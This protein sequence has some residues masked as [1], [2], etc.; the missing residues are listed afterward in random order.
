MKESLTVAKMVALQLLEPAISSEDVKDISDNKSGHGIHIHFP[1]GATPK[2]GP[3]AGVAITTLLWAYYSGQPIPGNLAMTGEIDLNGK[4][5]AIG[6]LQE[7]LIGAKV[8]GIQTVFI[9]KQN[10]RDLRIVQD[11]IPPEDLPEKILLIGDIQDVIREI[12]ALK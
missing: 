4:V 7:K 3:S 12:S 5:L 11:R 1:E 6:G 10:E 8:D 9:P 2:D